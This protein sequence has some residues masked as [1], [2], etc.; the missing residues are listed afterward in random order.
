MISLAIRLLRDELDTYLQNDEV[1]L[2]NVADLEG[3]RAGDL[4]GKVIISL[5]NIEEESSLK[6][7]PV[8][9]RNPQTNGLERLQPPIHL[10]LYLLFS[11]APSISEGE[12]Y[13]V[14]LN[15]LSNVIEF[16]Q[17]KTQFTAAN[18]PHSTLALTTQI[19]EA[20]KDSIKIN[21]EL[22]TLTF[23]QQNHLWG[24]LGGKQVPAALFKARLV[25]IQ[26]RLVR[27]APLIQD[28]NGEVENL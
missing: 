20:V 9:Q 3:D 26:S 8:Y 18:S 6:N 25:A 14:A 28:I 27:E 17:N 7:Q 2:E 13:E 5:V 10:N 11:S 12:G 22:Y 16:F 15:R 19:S 4:R 1:I 23:E 21:V 24:S